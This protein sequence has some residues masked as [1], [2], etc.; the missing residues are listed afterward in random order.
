MNKMRT[1]LQDKAKRDT[2]VESR[3]DMIGDLWLASQTMGDEYCMSLRK[4]LKQE[5]LK[6][7]DDGLSKPNSWI[8]GDSVS[9]EHTLEGIEGYL[10][11]YAIG[12]EDGYK[13]G[14]S[15]EN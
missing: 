13:R 15:P 6:Q 11:E 12:Y 7:I 3:L 8:D 4:A 1:E 10:S 5:Y 14:A 2:F 9:F